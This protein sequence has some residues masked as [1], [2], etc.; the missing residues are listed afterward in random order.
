MVQSSF[1][2]VIQCKVTGLQYG[3]FLLHPS[4]NGM[5]RGRPP[6]VALALPCLRPG[7]QYGEFLRGFLGNEP[8][9]EPHERRSDCHGT[10]KTGDGLHAEPPTRRKP[11]VRF[12]H[13]GCHFARYRVSR[14]ASAR[15]APAATRWRIRA[16][17]QRTAT[18]VGQR[19]FGIALGY[20]DLND[21][22]GTIR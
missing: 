19:A 13:R 17:A 15:F 7:L 12:G 20:E 11:L 10:G 8:A 6:L 9:L 1:A 21:H 14:I 22:C 3:E 2:R 5:R 18:L 16:W 4:G